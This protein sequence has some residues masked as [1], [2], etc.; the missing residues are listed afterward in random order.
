LQSISDGSQRARYQY[1]D[2]PVTPDPFG[3]AVCDN[4]GSQRDRLAKESPH[5]K[6]IIDN[7]RDP[8]VVGGLRNGCYVRYVELRIPNGFDVNSSSLVI[9]GILDVTRILAFDKL[10]RNVEL[11]HVDTELNAIVSK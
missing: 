9:Y 10:A 5:P 1:F 2:L 3:A 4:V 11:L 6:S 7:K 8:G